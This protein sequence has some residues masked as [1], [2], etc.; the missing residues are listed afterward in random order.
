M[1]ETA[2]WR[3]GGGEDNTRDED[4]SEQQSTGKIEKSTCGVSAGEASKPLDPSPSSPCSTPADPTVI[5]E[6]GVSGTI[7]IAKGSPVMFFTLKTR[8]LGT[9]RKHALKYT[10]GCLFVLRV[11]MR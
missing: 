3:V 4:L 1:S 8:T 5:G 11:C 9:V 10:C 6:A 7:L 2:S